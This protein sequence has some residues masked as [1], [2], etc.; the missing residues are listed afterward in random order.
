MKAL[1]SMC[2]VLVVLLLAGRLD[3]QILY[4]SIVGSVKD[5]SN[6]AIGGAKVT[7]TSK[8]TNQT[9]EAESSEFGAFTLSTVPSGIYDVKI[10]RE[11]FQAYSTTLTVSINSVVRVDATLNVGAV[12]ESVM[13]TAQSAALQTDRTEVRSEVTSRALVNVPVVGQRNY[14]NL[15]VTLPGFSVPTNAH[16]V[17]SNPSRALTFNANGT[18]RS[19]V[20]VRIDGASN[21][22]IWLPYHGVAVENGL[23]VVSYVASR[24]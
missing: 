6:A 21:T 13:V 5:S 1:R 24:G 23:E 12:T 20:N 9:R 19:S 4:G 16:S 15:F 14:Q 11:G 7:I 2:S 17:P 3:A 8:E 22:N 10:V 18:T